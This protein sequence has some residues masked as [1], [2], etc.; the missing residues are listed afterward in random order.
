M[1]ACAAVS[2]H[3]SSNSASNTDRAT[4]GMAANTVTDANVRVIPR[5]C[6]AMT[7][8]AQ[9]QCIQDQQ[10]RNVLDNDRTPRRQGMTRGGGTSAPGNTG[11]AGTT[12]TTG[13]SSGNAGTAAAGAAG[14]MGGNAA[15]NA[16]G[17]GSAGTAGTTGS[18]GAGATGGGPGAAGVGTGGNGGGGGG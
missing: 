2:A 8:D 13:S 9:V 17:T 1:A 14:G 4:S 16:S 18:S 11:P 3:G 5:D 15:G 7:G 10:S 12:G 6:A